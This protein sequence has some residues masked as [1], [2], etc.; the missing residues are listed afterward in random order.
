[1]KIGNLEFRQL[2][3]KNFADHIFIDNNKN[4][5]LKLAQEKYAQNLENKDFKQIVDTLSL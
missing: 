1:M 3:L 5:P 4:T 2:L